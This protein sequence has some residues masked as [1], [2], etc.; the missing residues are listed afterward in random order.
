[1]RSDYNRGKIIRVIGVRDVVVNRGSDDGIEVGDYIGIVDPN[2]EPVTD[3][4]SGA[5]LGG[6]RIYKASLRISTL[7]RR[8][9][10]ASTYKTT[11]TNVGGV[12]PD[13]DMGK[14]WS[15]P[16]FV[17]EMEKLELEDTSIQP[18][19]PEEVTISIG[20]EFEIIEKETADAGFTTADH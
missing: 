14:F 12:M 16:N 5:D 19:R 13:V 17:T 2:E 20:D 18:I 6:L 8:F 1:M 3:P 10:V 4:E 11:Q 9:A 15:P 7:S